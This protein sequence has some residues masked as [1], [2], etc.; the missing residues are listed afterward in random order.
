MRFFIDSKRGIVA[1]VF[2]IFVLLPVALADWRTATD[3]RA[4]LHGNTWEATFQDGLPCEIKSTVTG[5][6][7]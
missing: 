7:G 5:E 6:R 1:A 4:V 3:G 2:G